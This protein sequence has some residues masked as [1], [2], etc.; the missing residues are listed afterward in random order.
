MDTRGYIK[1]RIAKI[2][3]TK[4]LFKNIQFWS[5]DGRWFNCI[6][7]LGRILHTFEPNQKCPDPLES[8]RS[9]Q[10]WWLNWGRESNFRNFR[11]FYK[12]PVYATEI[13]CGLCAESQLNGWRVKCSSS[14]NNARVIACG[15]QYQFQIRLNLYWTFSFSCS[16]VYN[17]VT[18]F[19]C[20]TWQN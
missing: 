3:R 18:Y 7:S 5:D 2:P 10:L 15:S 9:W 19:Q 16:F 8:N 11:N 6:L 4:I 1:S 13:D 17:R 12:I 20:L 14:K